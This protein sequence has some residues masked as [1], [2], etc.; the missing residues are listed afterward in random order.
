MSSKLLRIN[1]IAFL[2]L[3]LFI[4]SCTGKKDQSP[5]HPEKA[6]SI[7]EHANYLLNSGE[8][9]NAIHYLDA[10][11]QAFPEAGEIDKWKKYSFLNNFYLNYEISPTRAEKYTDSMFAVL[12]RY[13][14][15]YP[16]Q[17]AQ[18]IFAKGDVL[19]TQKRH[20][21]AFER[22]YEGRTFTSKYLDS[23]EFSIFS[24]RLGLIRYAQQ[25]F[26][27][28]IPY[29]K[30]ALKENAHCGVEKSFENRFILPQS[31]YNNI[32]LSYEQAKIPDS[33]LFYY[34]EGLA[35]IDHAVP[36]F[37]DKAA[38]IQSARGVICG[39][40]GGQYALLNKYAEAEKYLKESIR[41]N[42]RPGYAR[43]DAITARD[44]LAT[45]Y[46]HSGRLQEA[47]RLI[48]QLEQDLAA[49]EGNN[50]EKE[51]MEKLFMRL[52]SNYY[53][54]MGDWPK[55]YHFLQQYNSIKDSMAEVAIGL[56]GSDIDAAFRQS[57]QQYKLELLSKNNQIKSFYL[58]AA[59]VISL[60]IISILM[61]VWHNLKRSR[62]YVKKLEELN[63][64][65]VAQNDQLQQTL[66]VLEQSHADNARMMKIV[67]H[68][69]RNPI[70]SIKMIS[71]LMLRK[72]K[73]P[74][75][76]MD[77]INMMERTSGDC[78]VMVD[79]LLQPKEIE[80]EFKKK[81]EDLYRILRNCI[82]QLTLKAAEKQQEIILDAKSLRVPVNAEK[83]WRVISNLVNNSIKFSPE[84]TVI[85]VTLREND[86][87]AL[88]TVLDHGIGIPAHLEEKIFDMPAEARRAGTQGES[89]FGLGLAISKQIVTAHQ[90]KIWFDATPGG[91]TTFYVELPL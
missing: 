13:K 72:S 67:A 75:E 21:E 17:Y 46:L 19:R 45:M 54:K 85:T 66:A 81:P 41:I 64:Q 36:L 35:F 88:I 56:R 14:L 86:K 57:E 53:G 83:L 30:Q 68:D 24:N 2:I 60:M 55:A 32:A 91:G 71:A 3:C 8:I 16:L 77:L 90:G 23:C 22:Y 62:K 6:D 76:D 38:Y 84:G 89:T 27:K 70:G 20:N 25:K 28:A 78:L 37:P 4:I 74:A 52:K 73:L 15:S 11:Y 29:F 44:K 49:R 1:R 50:S 48:G 18:T 79:E 5:D 31:I 26:L 69:L 58:V 51:L 40:I 12:E 65:A 7:L 33:A 87:A 59:I 34:R 61:I 43:E 47:G 80:G 42:D 39:N 82:D 10:S 9:N 63:L